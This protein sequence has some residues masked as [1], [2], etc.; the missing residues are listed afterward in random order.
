MGSRENKKT[1][2][3]GNSLTSLIT[4]IDSVTASGKY[5]HPGIIFKGEDL[6]WQWF[7]REFQRLVPGWK[8]TT[9]KNGWTS[10]E[11]ALYWL[12]D[13]FLPQVQELREHD[14]SRAVL[15][16]LDGHKSHTTVSTLKCIFW[17]GSSANIHP[18]G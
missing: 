3:K 14:E 12:E 7:T 11:I 2:V 9:S 4:V 18:P 17:W 15:L 10:N 8:F 5:L 16:I 13:V 1:R 6:Q